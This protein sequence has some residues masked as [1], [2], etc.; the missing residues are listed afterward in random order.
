[1]ERALLTKLLSG[2][3]INSLNLIKKDNH[4]NNWELKI[5]Y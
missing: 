5:D 4:S 2:I 1:M 3:I